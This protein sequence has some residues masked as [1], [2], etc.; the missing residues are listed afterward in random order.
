MAGLKV[1]KTV[2]MRVENS[3]GQSAFPKAATM[4]GLRAGMTA[5]Y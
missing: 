4:A 3:A 5:A 1:L 2:A